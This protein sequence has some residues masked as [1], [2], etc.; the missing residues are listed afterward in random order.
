M[1]TQDEKRVLH[2]AHLLQQ[3]VATPGWKVYSEMLQDRLELEANNAL[4]GTSSLDGV[5]VNEFAKGTFSGIRF[6]MTLPEVTVNAAK[7]IAR[8][9]GNGTGG[10]AKDFDDETAPAIE[11]PSH[12]IGQSP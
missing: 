3:L 5:L 1:T 8:R 4:A 7:E 12:P 6:A 11:L 9:T 10:Q 2:Q